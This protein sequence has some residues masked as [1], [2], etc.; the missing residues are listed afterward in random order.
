MGLQLWGHHVS[1]VTVLG[2]YPFV[3]FI[4]LWV[5]RRGAH[6]GNVSK[7]NKWLL[8]LPYFHLKAKTPVII[9]IGVFVRVLDRLLLQVGRQ[10]LF[11]LP[12]V[13]N[14]WERSIVWHRATTNGGQKLHQG[15]KIG[16]FKY[17]YW[18]Q[19]DPNPSSSARRCLSFAASPL[20]TPRG[21]MIKPA[22]LSLNPGLAPCCSESQTLR[23]GLVRRRVVYSNASCLRKWRS[24]VP[25]PILPSEYRQRFL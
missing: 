23:Q 8:L 5:L 2:Y 6:D 16:P 11:H 22:G 14:W 3:H 21:E 18:E 7:Q 17:K 19:R 12:L 4:N 20:Q 24:H 25:K 10:F 15:T 9:V 1:Q 13:L